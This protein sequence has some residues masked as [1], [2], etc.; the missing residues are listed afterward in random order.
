MEQL[1]EGRSTFEKQTPLHFASK[2]G[3]CSVAECFIKEFNA[4]KEA[5]DYKN[6][7]PLFIAAEFSMFYYGQNFKVARFE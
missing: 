4:D 5:K 1:L 7:T 3:S 2:E 6:R